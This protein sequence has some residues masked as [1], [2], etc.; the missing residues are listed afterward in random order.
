MFSA[1]GLYA[2]L[3]LIGAIL[4]A[5]AGGYWWIHHTGVVSGREEVQTKWDADKNRIKIAEEKAIA[6]RLRANE[7]KQA[8]YEAD[9]LKLKKGYANEIA[10][11]RA[12]SATAGRLRLPASVCDGFAS[13]GDSKGT[14]G[15][16]AAIAGTVLLPA[17]ISRNIQDLARQADEI[18]AGCRVAQEFIKSQGMAP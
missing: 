4:A 7:L 2:K 16:S 17:S 9:K 15:S 12:D 13:G 3:A 8:Q 14:S 11:I 1:I 10:Q 5:L 6:D 18:V